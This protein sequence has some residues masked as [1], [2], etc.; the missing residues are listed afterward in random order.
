MPWLVGTALMHSLAVTEKRGGFKV[1]TVLLA[2]VAFSLS[3]L[4]TF[5]VR[6]GVLSSVHAFATD[7]RRGLFILAFLVVVIGSSLA[8]YAWRAPKMSLGQRFGLMSR[9]SMLLANNM[10]LVAAAGAVLLGTMYPLLLDALNLGKISVGPPYFDT[11]FSL[12][13][14]PL[15]LTM[16]IGPLVRWRDDQLPVVIRRLRW[17]LV[18]ALVAALIVGFLAGKVAIATTCGLLMAF[19]IVGSMIT[20]LV[21]RLRVKGASLSQIVSRAR[22]LP[23]AFVGMMVAHIGV[24]VFTFGVTMVKTFETERDVKMSATDTTEIAGYTFR[25]IG[26]QEDVPGP[27][28]TAAIGMIEVTRDG[29]TIATLRPEKRVYRVQ[30]NPMTEA[31]IDSNPIRDLYVSMGERLSGGEWIVRVQYKP[32]IVWVWGGCL[33][34]MAGG[35]LAVSDRRYRSRRTADA[36]SPI[37]VAAGGVA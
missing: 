1:W 15:V 17:Q 4:G 13:M 36:A 28:Y 35:I 32:F 31:A 34:M 29:K 11:V 27:N 18:G 14:G 23:R 2:I 5:I 33:M 16:G 21:E 25:M 6:S 10:L 8:L 3:L 22:M 26:Y 30:Q 7:P 37:E 19:W 12:L 9:E 24:A 20:D